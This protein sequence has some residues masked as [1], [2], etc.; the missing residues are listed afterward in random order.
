MNDSAAEADAVKASF[1][2]TSRWRRDVIR[3]RE[4]DVTTTDVTVTDVIAVSSPPV[5]HHERAD[6][7]DDRL[8]V[9]DVQTTR[10]KDAAGMHLVSL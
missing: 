1:H 7:V 8:A 3:T 2:V 9:A 10:R 6:D 5:T 4:G